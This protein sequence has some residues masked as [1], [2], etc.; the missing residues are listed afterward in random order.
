MDPHPSGNLDPPPPLAADFEDP[1]C[2]YPLERKHYLYGHRKIPE[3]LRMWYQS[4]REVI[5]IFLF[6]SRIYYKFNRAGGFNLRSTLQDLSREHIFLIIND[7]GIRVPDTHKAYDEALKERLLLVARRDNPGR[8]K[9]DV[10]QISVDKLR[11]CFKLSQYEELGAPQA[12]WVCGRWGGEST[13]GLPKRCRTPIATAYSH[14][15]EPKMRRRWLCTPGDAIG[16]EIFK[17]MGK[18]S[19]SIVFLSRHQKRSQWPKNVD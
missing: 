6:E 15:G 7:F 3:I 5:I 12:E 14:R 16:R 2:N 19:S 4:S 8:R 17:R 11:E 18:L 13:I 9:D 1:S 10:G